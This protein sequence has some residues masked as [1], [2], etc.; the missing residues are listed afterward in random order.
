MCI[1]YS[2]ST[3]LLSLRRILTAIVVNDTDNS[4]KPAGKFI[5]V[6]GLFIAA[7]L[8]KTGNNIILT[9]YMYS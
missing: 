4:D 7:L 5:P 1:L 3:F 9:K 6:L 8:S 2:M